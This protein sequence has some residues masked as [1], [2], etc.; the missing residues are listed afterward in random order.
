M[1]PEPESDFAFNLDIDFLGLPRLE[2][3]RKKKSVSRDGLERRRKQDLPF[4]LGLR[5][6]EV[7]D[8]QVTTKLAW[9]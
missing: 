5:F 9:F 2:L 3:I 8:Q 7:S 6:S 4:F 1:T